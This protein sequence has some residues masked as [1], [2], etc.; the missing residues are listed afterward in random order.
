VPHGI[1]CAGTPIYL[2][3]GVQRPVVVP[4]CDRTGY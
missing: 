1:S 2:H 3:R 4:D